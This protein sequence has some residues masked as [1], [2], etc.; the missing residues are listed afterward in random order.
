MDRVWK[1]SLIFIMCIKLISK[2]WKTDFKGTDLLVLLALC[3]HADSYAQCFPSWNTL[4]R[5]TKVSK[6]SLS[7]TLKAFEKFSIIKR[8]HHHRANGSNSSNVYTIT[9]HEIDMNEFYAYKKSLKDKKT[10]QEEV[11]SVNHKSSTIELGD[12]VQPVK[13][14]SLTS[15]PEESS[16]SEIAYNEPPLSKHQVN[17]H[18]TPVKGFKELATPLRFIM[19]YKEKIIKAYRGKPLVKGAKGFL[20]DTM[21]S[22]TKD[23]YLFNE[24]AQKKLTKEEAIDVWQWIFSNQDKL[25]KLDKERKCY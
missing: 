10:N 6:G 8:E 14:S 23:G 15:E 20:A 22:L 24:V 4:M 19:Q 2:A 5:K 25:E 13:P 9:L 18:T 21:I 12:D 1:S 3:D 7:Y 16:P 17:H 11:H